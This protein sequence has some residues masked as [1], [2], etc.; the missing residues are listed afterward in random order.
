[1]KSVKSRQQIWQERRKEE[2]LC[3]SCGKEPAIGTLCKI[4]GE[5][6]KE[7]NRKKRKNKAWVSGGKGRKPIY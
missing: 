3:I 1:M 2:G 5:K 7:R 6:N 4:C